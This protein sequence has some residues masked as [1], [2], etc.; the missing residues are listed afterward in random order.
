MK[1]ILCVA[2]LVVAVPLAWAGN[3]PGVCQPN[4]DPCGSPYRSGLCPGG[5]NIECCPE[6]TSK[7]NGQCQ[8]DSLS[9]STGYQTGLCPGGN[10][11]KCLFSHQ[12]FFPIRQVL[13]ISFSIFISLFFFFIFF[14]LFFSIYLFFRLPCIFWRWWFRKPWN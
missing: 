7:C 11:I 12:T 14:I 5:S 8:V 3:C 9:C 6:S 10:D 2:L 4:S 1:L 13:L